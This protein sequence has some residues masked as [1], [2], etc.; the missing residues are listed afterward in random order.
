MPAIAVI[1]PALNEE[2]A[3]PVVLAQ[4]PPLASSVTVVDNGSTDATAARA[5]AAGARVVREPRRGYG[6]ACLA[7]L[8]VNRQADVIVFLDADLSDFPEEM[9]QL[10]D[11]ILRNDADFVL[12]TRVGVERPAHARLGTDLC[13]GLINR[14][15]GTTY[16]DLG[17]FRAI[18][19]D[20]L[21][22]LQMR[23][24]TWGWTIEMQVKAAEAGLR[25]L[26]VPVRQRDRVGRSK[27]SGTVVG[28][29]RAGFRMLS[30]I[31]HLWWTRTSRHRAV[32]ANTRRTRVV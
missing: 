30:T 5:A 23:D 12:G 21:D 9:Q 28:T 17:P 26:E 19:R 20:A 24:Q 29:F 15:W 27:I 16:H 22:R 2:A 3:I 25:V 31:G 6:R 7:G 4:V 1:I 32:Q 18:R 10:V 11:P 13:V 14:L 8:Q